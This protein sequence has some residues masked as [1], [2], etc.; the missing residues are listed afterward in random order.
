MKRLSAL[1][2]I[3]CLCAAV[4]TGFAEAAALTGEDLVFQVADTVFRPGDPAAP[5]VRALEAYLGTPLTVTETESCMFAGMDREYGCDALVLGTHPTGKNG[6]DALESVLV[7]AEPFATA[8]GIT[9]GMTKEEVLALYGT[10]GTEDWDE[11]VF[12]ES[13]TGASLVFVFDTETEQ[14]ICWMLLR[15]TDG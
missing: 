12:T 6:A 5:L 2:L 8:R 4:N 3:L 14:V 11:L 15:N 10:S 7:F 13:D 9:V 1:F